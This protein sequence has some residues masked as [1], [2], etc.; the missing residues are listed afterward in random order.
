MARSTLRQ[1]ECFVAVAERGSIA[2]AAEALHVSESAIA[3]ALN[4]LERALGTQLTIRRKA[5]GVTLTPSGSY[6][7]AQARGLLHG[8]GDLELHAAN[9]G[10]EL[11]GSLMLGC[12]LTLAPTVLAGLIA[13]FAQRHPAVQLD[14]FDGPQ[15][16]VQERLLAGRLD[17]AV[18]YDLSLPPGLGSRRLYD[19]V[20]AV[21]LAAGHPLASRAAIDLAEL[22]DEPMVLLDV[23][24][25]RENTLAMFSAAGLQPRIRFRTTDYEVTRSLVGRGMGYSI[26]VQRPAGDQSYEGRALAVRPIRP[27][28]RPVPVAIVWPD[29]VRPSQAASAMLDVASGLYAPPAGPGPVRVPTPRLP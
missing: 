16:E 24:P 12:Y 13:A 17:L 4:G 15:R 10:A 22:V 9:A 1:L 5:H 25:S 20:P 7:L 2:A 27:A 29:A 21:V 11:R 28:V 19:A 14:F 26:L 6:V 23:D 18:A 3:G 8:A